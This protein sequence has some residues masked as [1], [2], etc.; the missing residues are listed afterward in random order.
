[1]CRHMKEATM[2]YNSRVQLVTFYQPAMRFACGQLVLRLLCGFHIC[3]CVRTYH[4]CNN[5]VMY[6]VTMRPYFGNLDG[7]F[8]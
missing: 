3:M 1:M 7:C 8:A 5:Y 2:G 4:V 6:I